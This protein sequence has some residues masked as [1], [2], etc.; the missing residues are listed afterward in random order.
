MQKAM[1]NKDVQG[2]TQQAMQQVT[3]QAMQEATHKS[4]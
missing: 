2:T 1:Q 3:Q 4:V